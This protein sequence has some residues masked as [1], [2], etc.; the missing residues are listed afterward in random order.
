MRSKLLK[1]ASILCITLITQ[2]NA[3]TN[4]YLK[5]ATPFTITLKT[6]STL[7][8]SYW[9]MGATSVKPGQRVKLYN[10]NRNKGIKNNTTYEFATALNIKNLSSPAAPML[11]LK[12]TGTRF[13]SDMWHSSSFDSQWYGDRKSRSKT[14]TSASNRLKVSHQQYFA[15]ARDDVE[16]V[17]THSILI[18]SSGPNDLNVLAWNIYMRKPLAL[19]RNGQSERN[20]IIA[21]VISPNY[22]VLIFS[23]AWHGG[24]RDEL[25]SKLKGRGYRYAT[26]AVAQDAPGAETNGGVIIVSKWPIET[27]QDMIFTDCSKS[28]CLAA[29]GAMYAR[30][31]KQGKKYHIVGVHTQA[32]PKP[33]A[34]AIRE[35]QFT[36]L[37]KFIDDLNIPENEPVLI[38]GDMNVDK[39]K[40]PEEYK[41]MK[42]SLDVTHPA[43]SGNAYTYDHR[44]NDLAGDNVNEFLDYIFYANNHKKPTSSSNIVIMHKA[45]NGWKGGPFKTEKYDLSDHYAI[46]GRFTFAP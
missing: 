36:Q 37:K 3:G 21:Q 1:I 41:N 46:F 14:R 8:S 45:V 10:V 19:F 4:V 40:F 44:T 6:K 18:P 34:M 43:V 12:L 16:F 23:E 13:G 39:N 25:V 24:L 30:I 2:L 11:K 35:K 26:K 9:Q 20:P 38:G 29:K 15:G 28:D 27:S 32:W 22:D 42:K 17:L 5:N 7:N 31:N 33:E